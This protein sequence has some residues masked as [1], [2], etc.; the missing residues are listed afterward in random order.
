MIYV[1][2]GKTYILVSGYFKEVTVEEKNGS[3][4]VVPVKNGKKIEASTVKDF[5]TTSAQNVAKKQTKKLTD[6]Q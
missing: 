2:N 4:E 5:T 6:V 3:Y 1:I